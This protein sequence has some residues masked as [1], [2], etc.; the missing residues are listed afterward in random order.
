MKI[1]IKISVVL[2]L[3]IAMIIPISAYDNE[4]EIISGDG[5]F[6]NPYI[7]ADYNN[8]VGEFIINNYESKKGSNEGSAGTYSTQ[9][10][11]SS[12][13]ADSSKSVAD[14]GSYWYRTGGGGTTNTNGTM[15]FVLIDYTNHSQMGDLCAEALKSNVRSALSTIVSSSYS[16]SAAKSLLRGLGI[17]NKLIIGG[18]LPAIGH[19][20]VVYG[21]IST[22]AS[23][24]TALSDEVL[25]DTQLHDHHLMTVHYKTSYNGAWYM[26]CLIE[27]SMFKTFPQIPKSTYGT[28]TYVNSTRIS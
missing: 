16:T 2:S 24:S 23:F 19:A 20:A 21:G 10:F 5:S 27:E 13:L 22:Y 28:G 25:A 18:L 9:I 17:T 8:E 15:V 26:H 3:I 4:V 7:L 1:M 11:T 6:E 12:T 14:P